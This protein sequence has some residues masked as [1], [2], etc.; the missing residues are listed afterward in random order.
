MIFGVARE[1]FFLMSR[2]MCL[3]SVTPCSSSKALNS[4]GF[5]G[6]VKP[7]PPEGAAWTPV[8]RTGQ[9]QVLERG[10][11]MTVCVGASLPSELVEP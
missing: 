1:A 2:A 7:A 11:R 8:K 10:K 9:S 4:D 5:V 6:D 3:G